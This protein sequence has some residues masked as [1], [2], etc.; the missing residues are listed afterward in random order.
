M[1]IRIPIKEEYEELANNMYMILTTLLVF[2]LILSS[3]YG[4]KKPCCF[5]LTGKFL[6]ED[7]TMT[8]GGLFLSLLAYV[9]IF[10]KLV[11]FVSM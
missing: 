3:H 6:N 8:L 9:L 5:G 2:H 10:K 1:F 7:F 4:K 11:V